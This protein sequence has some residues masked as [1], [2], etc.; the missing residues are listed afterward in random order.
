[1]NSYQRALEKV[2]QQ[3][4]LRC[5][6]N[7]PE[8]IDFY[9][10]DYLGL[11]QNPEL[12][13][14]IKKEYQNAPANNGSTG[15]RLLSGNSDYAERIERQIAAFH[16]AECALVYLSGYTANLGLVSSLAT[17]ETTLICDELIH[18]SLI[19][20]ARLGKSERI[21]FQHNDIDDLRS[22]LHK[23]KGQKLVIVE[24]IYSMDGDIAPLEE[25]SSVCEQN[26]AMLIVDEA[27]AIGIF[28]ENGEGLVQKLGL[29]KKVLARI[30]TYGKAPGIHG[31]AVVGPN[32]IKEYQ[33]NFSRPLIFS[34]APS[35]HH[36]A[37]IAS[38]YC[39][40]PKAAKERD[41]LKKIVNYF[42]YKRS[43]NN[44]KWLNSYSHIQSL[45]V[46]GNEKVMAAAKKLQKVGINALPIRKPSVEEGT[47]RIRFCLH[48]YNT[49]EDIDLLF[50]SLNQYCHEQ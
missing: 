25:I 37:S 4:L 27:H 40:L 42:L 47:E 9:S 30:I 7:P 21:R 33:I 10:N 50:Q 19:D 45:I 20:G 23:I 16:H 3:H 49:K 39:Q 24:S 5:L 26:N 1:M 41:Q 31:A 14:A 35:Q 8:G 17:R 22:K 28:G 34:T 43:K 44:L 13:L 15:S 18:A 6:P 38:M 36:F 48:S 46:P 29:E 32:W 11:A 2:K 12:S